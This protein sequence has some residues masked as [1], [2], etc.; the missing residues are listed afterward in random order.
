MSNA[1]TV[2]NPIAVQ[3]VEV[4][5]AALVESIQA[6]TAKAKAIGAV[7]AENLEEA[8]AVAIAIHRDHSALTDHVEKITKPLNQVLKAVRT[9]RDNAEDPLLEAKRALTA[10]IGKFN[11]AEAARKE[12]ERQAALE[13]A[14]Q[15]AAKAEEERKRLQAEADAKHAAEVKAAQEKA[16]AEARELAEILGTPVPAAPVQVAPAPVVAA[17]KAVEVVVPKAEKPAA[18][19]VVTRKV[20]VLLIDNTQLIPAYI[21]GMELR[22]IDKAAIKRAIDAGLVVPGAHVEMQEQHAMGRVK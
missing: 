8:N 19:A 22:P 5:P 18:S 10:S 2:P 21:G 7:T 16:A 14:R 11:A 9:C 12:A 1:V 20:P 3:A 13:R 4:V 17:P 6:N 15:E